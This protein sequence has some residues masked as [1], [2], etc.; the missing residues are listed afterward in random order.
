MAKNIKKDATNARQKLRELK[1]KRFA[2]IPD[3]RK[4]SEK[5]LKKSKY[6]HLTEVEIK[7]VSNGKDKESN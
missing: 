6:H 4:A 7:T 2:C 5:L 1:G 3:A